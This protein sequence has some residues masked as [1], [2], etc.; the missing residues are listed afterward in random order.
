[1]RA[2]VAWSTTSGDSP[3]SPG[4][5]PDVLEHRAHFQNWD[6]STASG[7]VDLAPLARWGPW[8]TKG[9]S[10]PYRL[11]PVRLSRATL[12]A[13]RL[14]LARPLPPGGRFG[15][16]DV[17]VVAAAGR[18]NE[19][20]RHGRIGQDPAARPFDKAPEVAGILRPDGEAVRRARRPL[21]GARVRPAASAASALRFG[22][23][24]CRPPTA[25]PPAACARR[26]RRR[27]H[28]RGSCRATVGPRP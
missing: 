21:R 7:G 24:G 12:G 26:R 13:A 17:V 6:G 22:P 5:R 18:E 19:G 11:G 2:S 20:A 9:G 25:R 16:F 3:R 4:R 28:R 10:S 14:R 23:R 1:M 8:W 15:R 27:P